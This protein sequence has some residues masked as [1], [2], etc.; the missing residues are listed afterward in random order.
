MYSVCACS[1]NQFGISGKWF[2]NN[3][4]GLSPV[5]TLLKAS[6]RARRIQP[7]LFV[8]NSISCLSKGRVLWWRI[9]THS[10]WGFHSLRHV[11]WSFTRIWCSQLAYFILRYSLRLLVLFIRGFFHNPCTWSDYVTSNYRNSE[12]W[13]RCVEGI[14]NG[15]LT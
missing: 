8:Q 13:I 6:I 9:I 11:L 1:W 2:V 12:K 5:W 7:L 15:N 4:D 10:D 3:L 14:I